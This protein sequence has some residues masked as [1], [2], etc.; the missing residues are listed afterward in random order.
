MTM[1]GT[2]FDTRILIGAVLAFDAALTLLVCEV[3]VT[4]EVDLFMLLSQSLEL[5][6]DTTFL[7]PLAADACDYGCCTDY[8]VVC[9]PSFESPLAIQRSFGAIAF[10][11]VDFEF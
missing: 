5:R 4:G 1:D 6:L 10:S 9:E 3:L 7:N 2:G 8:E 11:V